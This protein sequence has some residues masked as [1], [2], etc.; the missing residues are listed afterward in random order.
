MLTHRNASPTPP[1]RA[2][3]IGGAGFV[4][5]AV[6]RRLRAS[7]VEV[8][9]LG[10]A[11]V[12][13]MDPGAGAA[14][15][16]LLRPG[17]AVV[18]ASARAPCRDVGMMIENMTLVRAVLAAFADSA[19]GHVVNISSDAVYGDEDAPITEAT[20]PSPGS[21]HGAM[22]LSREIALQGALGERLATLRPTLIH[23][24]TDPHNGYG[25]NRFRRLA[26]RAEEIVLFGEGEE[27]RD[28]VFVE[29]VADLAARMVLHRSAGVLNAATGAVHSF[30]AAA[31]LAVAQAG[32][33]SAIRG[34]PR[35]GPMPHNGHRPFD[36]AAT[37]AAFP[38]FRYVGLA[39]GL[40]RAAAEARH[41]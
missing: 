17:D 32:S 36:P 39:A 18:F 29:D 9:S 22:H 35:S 24:A 37:R 38:D 1:E 20:A 5:G 26:A 30:R 27:R 40:A 21:M 10:R 12:D 6:V 16:K 28:H 2:V 3:V 4:G 41:G 13:L 7:A 15:A 11:E 8:L 34:T 33:T 14:L 31:E 23:G 25:P 19:P